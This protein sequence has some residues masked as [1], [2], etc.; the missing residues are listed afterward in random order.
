MAG[1]EGEGSS[2]MEYTE[3]Q[4]TADC[5]DSCII[6]HTVNDVVG[7]VLY[8]H[9]Q[10]PSTL[11]DISMEFDTLQAEYKE[12]ERALTEPE[13]KASCRRKHTS[14][15]RDINL[16]IR[17]FGKFMN[18]VSNLQTALKLMISQIPS[19][20]EVILILGAS[21]LRPLHVYKLCFSHG[22]AIFKDSDDFAKSKAA[23]GLSR[24][25]IRTLISKG[26]GCGSY[27]GPTK[28]FLLIKA[29]SSCNLSLHFLPKRDFKYSKKILPFRLLFRCRNQD[30]EM[31]IPT[32]DDLIWFQCRHVIKGVTF[33]TTREE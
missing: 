16:G 23:E 12:L 19:I 31:I 20:E 8:M 15:M 3:I 13:V 24:K 17:R 9:Q 6:F 26:A 10:I 22:T 14:K 18:T 4:T 28:L 7:F 32:S 11:Q 1:I 27:P 2:E 29:P 33:N 21:P 30:Q 25:A 5:L